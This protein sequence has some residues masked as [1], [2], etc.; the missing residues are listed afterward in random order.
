MPVPTVFFMAAGSELLSTIAYLRNLRTP[1]RISSV[2]KGEPFRPGVYHV[3]EDV[4]AVEGHAGQNYR[5]ALNERYQASPEFRR[6][7]VKLSL[8]WSIPALAVAVISTAV[9]FTV[10][11]TIA[12]GIG[13]F[14]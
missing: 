5:K 10:P 14:V 12:F 4:I 9:V 1:I 3:I 7:L 6:M 11:A 8:A 13:K 2:A